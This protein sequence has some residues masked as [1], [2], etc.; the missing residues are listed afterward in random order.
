MLVVDDDASIRR[1]LRRWLHL[2]NY[3]VREA[4]SATEAVAAMFEARCSVVLCDIRMPGHDGFWVV[5]RIHE[6][7]PDTAVI[8][9]TGLDDVETVVRARREG[10]VDYI[11][12][13]FGREN[14]FQALE[15]AMAKL[16]DPTAGEA[17]S[18]A[19]E[20]DPTTSKAK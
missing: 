9:V 3:E 17:N 16:E 7:W 13:P 8:M 10:A 2:W 5:E 19:S 11:T 12:K 15:R 6:A 20:A 18:T 1:V 14:L 4:S